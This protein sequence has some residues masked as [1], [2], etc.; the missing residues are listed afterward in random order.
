MPLKS[1]LS[2]AA[3]SY[4]RCCYQLAARKLQLLLIAVLAAIPGCE[5]T[6]Q[7]QQ[8]KLFQ[9]LIPSQTGITFS[10]T[11]P[12]K[13]DFNILNYLYYYNGAGVAVGDIDGDGLP[14]LYFTS[15]LGPNKLY[16]N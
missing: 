6:P 13:P 8:P 9:L 12:E 14:D 7:P 3:N 10:N 5:R 2:V 15:N 4:K 16:R 11:L 1:V